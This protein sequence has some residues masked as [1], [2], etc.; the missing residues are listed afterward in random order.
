MICFN[1]ILYDKRAHK[2]LQLILKSRRKLRTNCAAGE[3]DREPR[4]R[5]ESDIASLVEKQIELRLMR[6]RSNRLEFW[7]ELC[8]CISEQNPRIVTRTNRDKFP[9]PIRGI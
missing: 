8:A 3:V 6:F 2:D 7:P 5:S 9:E 1:Q 4:V